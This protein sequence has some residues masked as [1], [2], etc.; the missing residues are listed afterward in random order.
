MDRNKLTYVPFAA[1]V[2]LSR[3]AS[4][5]LDNRIVGNYVN[6]MRSNSFTEEVKQKQW[7]EERTAKRQVARLI[8][9]EDVRSIAVTVIDETSSNDGG[10]QFYKM[11]RRA[12]CTNPTRSKK[13]DL[14]EHHYRLQKANNLL[15]CKM[16]SK[17]TKHIR[18]GLCRAC[19]RKWMSGM[20]RRYIR[21]LY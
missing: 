15:P 21:Y 17:E 11:C 9:G 3:P 1:N 14:C 4:N 10:V 19:K 8:N 20:R 6:A 18:R 16:C 13:K 7:Q 5:V 12:D 2:D